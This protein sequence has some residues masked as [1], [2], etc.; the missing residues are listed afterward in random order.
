MFCLKRMSNY[1]IPT[2]KS[3]RHFNCSVFKSNLFS[4]SFLQKIDNLTDCIFTFCTAPDT[5]TFCSEN[6]IF[7]DWQSAPK[8]L[9][10]GQGSAGLWIP[11]PGFPDHGE[12]FRDSRTGPESGFFVRKS[13]IA[14]SKVKPKCR[15]PEPEENSGYPVSRIFGPVYSLPHTPAP[16]DWHRTSKVR[17]PSNQG[18]EIKE[19]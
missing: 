12:F 11:C 6:W 2:L 3:F 1:G 18:W 13:G 9:A 4:Y 7:W 14:V 15:V 16:D 5:G 8:K 19:S 17:C 10:P